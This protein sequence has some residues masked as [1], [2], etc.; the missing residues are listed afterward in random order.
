MILSLGCQLKSSG[1]LLGTNAQ[2]VV[3]MVWLLSH[4]Q[5][6]RPHGL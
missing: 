1:E 2:T 5:L 3:V 4:V 6:L